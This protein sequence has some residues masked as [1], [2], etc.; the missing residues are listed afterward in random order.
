LCDDPAEALEHLLRTMVRVPD[1][2]AATFRD[3]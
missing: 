3:P 2:P 1:V